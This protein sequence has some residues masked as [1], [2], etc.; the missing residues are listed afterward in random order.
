[1]RSLLQGVKYLV[2]VHTYITESLFALRRTLSVCA[3]HVSAL[4]G[5][6]LKVVELQES[7]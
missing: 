6:D 4:R 3:V 5:R 1:M 2:R 7:A